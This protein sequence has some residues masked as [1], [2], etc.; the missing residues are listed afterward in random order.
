MKS[1]SHYSNGPVCGQCVVD[2]DGDIWDDVIRIRKC[3]NR[4]GDVG[5]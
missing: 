4:A 2:V 1:F 3:L 5:K